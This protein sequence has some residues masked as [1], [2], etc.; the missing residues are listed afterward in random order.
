MPNINRFALKNKRV[1]IT[2]PESQSEQLSKLVEVSGG[3]ALV[4]PT[5]EIKPVAIESDLFINESFDISI[6][7][8]KNA[9]DYLD[10]QLLKRLRYSDCLAIGK[11]TAHALKQRDISNITYPKDDI[12]S[13]ALL[14]LPLLD[15]ENIRGKNIC[16]VKGVGGR[17]LIEQTLQS[18]GALVSPLEVYKRVKPDTD[19]GKLQKLWHKQPPDVIVITSGEGLENL[20]A[21][22][23]DNDK[24]RL[25][26][27]PLVVISRRLANIAISLGFT[28]EPVVSKGTDDETILDAIV[29]IFEE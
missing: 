26:N 16:L 12:G 10:K 18:R 1:M 21:M 25:L 17:E 5:V 29:S 15:E 2:R 4:F 6:F 27:C 7:I 28:I 8:S 20:L 22:V 11:G 24:P 3:R 19:P 23:S 9:V 13:E 14:G